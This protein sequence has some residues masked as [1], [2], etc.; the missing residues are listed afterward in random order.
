MIWLFSD[1]KVANC[2]SRK[3][4]LCL[5]FSKVSNKAIF[6]CHATLFGNHLSIYFNCMKLWSKNT[7]TDE[8][9]IAGC[10]RGERLMQEGLYKKYA[11]VLYPICL[12]YSNDHYQAEDMLQEA[13]VKIFFNLH[14][15]RGD[16]SFEGWLK[17]ISVNTAIEHFKKNQVIDNMADVDLQHNK[18]VQ[19]DD[20]GK[21]VYEDLMKLVQS[22]SPG[23][24]AV[25]NLY[26]IEGYS[27]KEISD[28][29]GI[30]EGTSKSQ[31]ARARYMLQKMIQRQE[32]ISYAAA[33]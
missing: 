5:F 11:S 16:G 22:L 25:F 3:K 2:F 26:A 24:R 17:R 8:N 1:C 9:L 14:K 29:L 6:D 31:L 30:S 23:Y 28:M 19:R 4:P 20:F 12:R 10:L 13:F 18:L 21:L 7:D 15:F 27:H 33:F 32:K